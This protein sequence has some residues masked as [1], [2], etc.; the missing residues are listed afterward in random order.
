MNNP[1]ISIPFAKIS[2]LLLLL[3]GSVTSQID[4]DGN[5]IKF[6]MINRVVSVSG[7]AHKGEPHYLKRYQNKA[8]RDEKDTYMEVR[9]V[10]FSGQMGNEDSFSFCKTTSFRNRQK[11]TLHLFPPLICDLSLI[12]SH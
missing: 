7:G 8:D 2:I 10:E 9:T 5:S 4:P 11:L 6:N 3:L 12:C 1:S